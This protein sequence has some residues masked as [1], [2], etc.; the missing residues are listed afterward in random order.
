MFSWKIDWPTAG[1]CGAEATPVIPPRFQLAVLWC[2]FGV[3]WRSDLEPER[4]AGSGPIFV[5]LND[6]L[7][8]AD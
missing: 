5:D 1:G 8:L 6:V 4:M 7:S 2:R 3:A